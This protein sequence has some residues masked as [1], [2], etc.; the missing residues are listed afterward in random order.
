MCGVSGRYRCYNGLSK[1]PLYKVWKNMI[2]RVYRKDTHI[3]KY[4]GGRGIIVCDEWRNDFLKFYDWALHNGWREG[5]E[6]DRIDTDGNYA[7]ENCR[8]VTRKENII[9]RRNTLRLEYQGRI[10]T[11]DEWCEELGLDK[12]SIYYRIHYAKWPVDK[13]LSYPIIRKKQV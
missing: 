8:W 10:Q 9:N 2:D 4:Y 3:F 7:P 1:H 11:L 12:K 5:L 13:A 6:I